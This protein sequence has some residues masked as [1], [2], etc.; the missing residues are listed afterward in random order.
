MSTLPRP[1]HALL[2]LASL[3]G[4]A[5]SLLLAAP[6]AVLADCMAPPPIAE[7]VE[8]AEI[9]FVGTVTGALEQGRRAVVE[10]DEVWRGPD[11]EVTVVVLGG[12]GQGISSVDRTYEVGTK[13]I[14]FPYRD[15]DTSALVDNL[16]TNTTPWLDDYTEL[17]PA[18]AREPIGEGAEG[19]GDGFDV[20]ALLPAGAIVL[21][22]AAV[23]LVAGLVAR[24]REA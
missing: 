20:A 8:T 12:Q 22:V 5:A 1:L 19:P 21:I 17:R 3:A 2:R 18:D 15:P 6:G 4:I 23:L 7:A 24:G 11:Q 9:V 16:C 14:F 13:Y 10:V